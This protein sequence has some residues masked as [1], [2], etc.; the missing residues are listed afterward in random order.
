[1]SDFEPAIEV[2]LKHECPSP[3]AP[4][5]GGW[6]NDPRDKG[7]ATVYGISTLIINREGITAKEMSIPDLSPQS[8]KLVTVGT[9]KTIY[10][11]L[12]WD[13]FGYN[14]ISDQRCASKVMDAAVNCGPGNGHRQ[15]QKACT[16]AGVP[17][18]VVDGIIGPNT[19][20][21]I[22]NLDPQKFLTCMVQT[23]T[24]YYMAIVARDPSQKV[25]LN[26]WLN[27]RAKWVG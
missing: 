6:V 7:G 2:V 8:L 13:R 20:A 14:R 19:V 3:I 1:M 22:N 24:D 27:T 16:L 12:F 21:A 9:A 11:K 5:G 15:A 23:M 26:N 4:V 17:L 10:K 18:M 25:W